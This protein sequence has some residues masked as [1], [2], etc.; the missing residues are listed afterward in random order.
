[1]SPTHVEQQVLSVIAGGMQNGT[2][3]LEDSL[4]IA[5]KTKYTGNIWS[6]THAPQ[7]LPKGV[8]NLCPHRNL[9]R[10]FTAAVFLIDKT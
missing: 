5:Y 7:Y 4:V 1:M 9:H 6:S 2:A 3:T 8:E 10:V